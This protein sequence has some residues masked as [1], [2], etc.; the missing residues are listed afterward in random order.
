MDSYRPSGDQS[1]KVS[2]I[3]IRLQS[4]GLTRQFTWHPSLRISCTTGGQWQISRCSR[5]SQI[6]SFF[7]QETKCTLTKVLDSFGETHSASKQLGMLS[8]RYHLA[9]KVLTREEYQELRLVPGESLIQRLLLIN[10]FG[11]GQAHLQRDYGPIKQIARKTQQGGLQICTTCSS[12]EMYKRI[13]PLLASANVISRSV[14]DSHGDYSS[15]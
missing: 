14:S 2:S 7:L 1:R 9:L 3:A 8:T 12:V 15:L 6:R 5:I 11:L 10:I 13:R 4:N